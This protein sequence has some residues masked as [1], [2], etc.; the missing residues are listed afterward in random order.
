MR[1]GRLQAIT[2][3]QY[4][5]VAIN[6]SN[7]DQTLQLNNSTKNLKFPAK[8]VTLVDMGRITIQNDEEITLAKIF[9]SDITFN[10]TTVVGAT[11]S[12]FQQPE[13]NFLVHNF[14]S[15]A[16]YVCYFDPAGRAVTKADDNGTQEYKTFF[17]SAPDVTATKSSTLLRSLTLYGATGG[18]RYW[19]YVPSP[20]SWKTSLK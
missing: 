20:A 3:R 6:G 8:S 10:D 9:P 2:R 14:S 12:I 17:I 19:R 11:R 4:Y 18:L 13:Q 5:A 1:Q 7:T 15:T 16:V